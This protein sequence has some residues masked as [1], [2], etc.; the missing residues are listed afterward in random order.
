MKLTET[1]SATPMKPQK[2]LRRRDVRTLTSIRAGVINPVVYE[3]LLL[4]D[5]ARGQMTIDLQ[6]METPETLMNAISVTAHAYF[7][8]FTAFERFNNGLE[9]FQR[10]YMG[11]PEREGESPIPLFETITYSASDPFWNVMGIHWPQGA[12]INSAP[13]EAY[14]AI[15]NHRRRARS[16][17]LP[18][19]D[20]NSTALARC[21][22]SRN[23]LAYIVPDYD[24]AEIH[25]YVELQ[26]GATQLP[27]SG[28]GF[29]DAAT[30]HGT[31]TDVVE[32]DGSVTV[33]EQAVTDHNAQSVIKMK[34]ELVEGNWLPR[35]FA[36]LGEAQ[37][38]VSLQNIELAKKTASFAKLRKKYADMGVAAGDDYIIDLLMQG[39][40]VPSA[41]MNQPILLDRKTTLVGY[42]KRYASDA[43]NLD[44]A[45]T[46]G[47]TFVDLSWRTPPMNTGGIIMVTVEIVPE[48]VVERRKDTFLGVT[49][50]AQ[51]PNAL[52][53]MLDPEPVE[54]VRNDFVDV[55]H[56]NPTGI[57]GYAETNH[58]WRQRDMANIGGK[59]M[60]NPA[61]SFDEDR[62]RLWTVDIVD[63]ELTEYFYLCPSPFPHDVFADS[64][65]DPFECTV[66]GGIDVA[67]NTYFPPRLSEDTGDYEAI[68]Q[69]VDRSVLSES[70]GL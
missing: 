41:A 45:V 4:E 62:Q 40:R 27:V 15:V 32:T 7:V 5:A 46:T 20:R 35:I 13:V 48:Q 67:G 37:G 8:P 61:D 12:A 44:K 49:S 30:P 70:L 64:V 19:R 56:T 57:F 17:K 18:Q 55:L 14:N 34:A 68:L 58:E 51:L 65:A 31:T 42:S 24:E 29:N 26:L 6:M 22:W 11:Q 2:T 63:P 52:T 39:V 59:F 43:A 21:F 9:T 23:T 1:I 38:R 16:V 66:L 28:I 60:R 50:G 3:P 10:S 54:V 47:Q 33:Y 36:E 25:G 53:D 69:D